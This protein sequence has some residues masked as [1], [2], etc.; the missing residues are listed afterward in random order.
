ML[1][2]VASPAMA[3][4]AM[5]LVLGAAVASVHSVSAAGGPLVDD[6]LSALGNTAPMAPLLF[7][8]F[9]APFS[10]RSIPFWELNAGASI[11]MGELTESSSADDAPEKQFVRLT[12]PRQSR[13]GAIWNSVPVVVPNWQ[14]EVDFAV[15]GRV[16]LGGDG[17]AL[18]FVERGGLL[19]TVYGSADHWSGLAVIFDT[20]NNDRRG[21]NPL[22]SAVF[23]DGT[24]RFDAGSD[25]ASQALASCSFDFRNLPEPASMRLTYRN[26]SL[27][28]DIALHRDVETK[29]P[30]WSSCFTVPHLQLGVDKF[31]GL[32][33]HTGDIADS[34][35]IYRVEMRELPPTPVS[36]AGA[37]GAAAAADLSEQGI[38]QLREES[39][40]EARRKYFE[41]IEAQRSA[42]D[43][44]AR[45]GA[46]KPAEGGATPSGKA[47]GLSG[48]AAD[49]SVEV[50]QHS[51]LSA[52]A[53]IQDEVNMIEQGQMVVQEWVAQ[54]REDAAAGG[55]PAA[56]GAAPP[57]GYAG[58]DRQAVEQ[59]SA[60]LRRLA[61]VVDSRGAGD[62]GG[63]PST[64]SMLDDASVRQL[65]ASVKDALAP[66]L[67][68]GAPAAGGSS[69][70]TD[71]AE[72]RT[73]RTLMVSNHD[74]SARRVDEAV[75]S[76]TNLA[77]QVSSLQSSTAD[78]TTTVNKILQAVEGDDKAGGLFAKLRRAGAAV[79]APARAELSWSLWL[80][81]VL[82]TLML[83]ALS[84]HAV[85]QHR[86]AKQDRY[87][88]M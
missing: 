24:Q 84:M 26:A 9:A 46:A 29:Q 47:T 62:A 14:I 11:S 70:A 34:H 8:S 35:D 61:K 1:A 41:D 51:V 67:R 37:G 79:D 69:A 50:F 30:Q 57:A 40:A 3:V 17:F 63:R 72:L 77:R 12:P 28:L 25:G 88:F 10:G 15:K 20:F 31:V 2:R 45:G 6:G 71:S 21:G 48:S 13:T 66:L 87:K 16:D 65:S 22:I 55:K 4:M 5:L 86:R 53:Q 64:V 60:E 80:C 68:G 49:L 76:L 59:V 39:V 19:G 32:S 56:G 78:L 81:V 75:S 58:I 38:E 42:H 27:T 44:Q 33:A 54:Q 74:A 36:A 7:H 85:V 43:R 73:L 83:A 18:W 82:S 23:N 52:L